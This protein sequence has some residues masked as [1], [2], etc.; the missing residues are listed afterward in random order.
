MGEA[1]LLKP[2]ENVELIHVEIINKCPVGC[3]HA[4]IVEKL[5]ELWA[6]AFAGRATIRMQN[7]T[8]RIFILVT[9]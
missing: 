3:N 2:D 9:K 5:N 4:A 6:Q 7:P 8:E 1:G